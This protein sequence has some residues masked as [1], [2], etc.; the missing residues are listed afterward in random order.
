M[1]RLL[2]RVRREMLDD[3]LPAVLDELYRAVRS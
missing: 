2:G 3:G 1:A